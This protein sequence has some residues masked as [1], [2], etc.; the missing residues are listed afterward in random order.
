MDDFEITFGILNINQI[1]VFER[2]FCRSENNELNQNVIF[3]LMNNLVFFKLK[4]PI[5]MEKNN[6]F[7]HHYL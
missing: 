7:Y 2:E 6:N 1:D 4:S 3:S 5:F